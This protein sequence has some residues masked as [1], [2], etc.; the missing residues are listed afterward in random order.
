MKLDLGSVNLAQNLRGE[1]LL[2]NAVAEAP[3]PG[4]AKH[5]RGVCIHDVQVMGDIED[6]ELL[7]APDISQK[8]INGF[9]AGDVYTTLT[10]SQVSGVAPLEVTF[11]S[12]LVGGPDDN[13]DYYC[14]ESVFD[15]GD[16]IGRSATP[17]C[18]EW[19]P[20]VDIQRQF[21]ASFVYDQPGEYQATFRLGE[22][23]S[24][25]VTIIVRDT[26]AESGADE[27]A[28]TQTL[29]SNPEDTSVGNE[30]AADPN[31]T[32]CLLGLLP[33]SLLGVVIGWRRVS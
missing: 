32:G 7:M 25:P 12:E 5:V 13:L 33:L 30:P 23:E 29:A 16:G 20:G 31:S 18:T 10:A 8:R 4:Q 2:R 3:E 11:T 9:A 22:A 27:P 26:G 21:T 15:F 14:V 1:H 6:G 24:E 17:D 28:S 19:Q